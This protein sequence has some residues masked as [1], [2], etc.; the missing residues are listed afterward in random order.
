MNVAV[1]GALLHT[2]RAD[3]DQ[4]AGLINQRRAAPVRVGRRHEERF[5]Q[6]VFPIAGERRPGEQPA[7][8][9]VGAAAGARGDDPVFA[10]KQTR[11]SNRQRRQVQWLER[12]HQ[13][14]SRRLVGAED[15]SRHAASIACGEDHLVRFGDQVADRQNQAF[16]ADDDSVADAVCAKRLGGRC[17]IADS[18]LQRD[19]RG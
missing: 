11:V 5:F 4:F 6:I 12:V 17:A 14:K 18:G 7:R 19:D 9:G 15:M 13:A 2:Q 1:G 8:L 10:A 3:P 16:D